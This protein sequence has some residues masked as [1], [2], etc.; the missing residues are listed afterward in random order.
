[1]GEFNR[2][3]DEDS[4]YRDANRTGNNSGKNKIYISS[5]EYINTI[6]Y[7]N[8]LKQQAEDKKN[9]DFKLIITEVKAQ[10]QLD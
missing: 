8:R 1:M 10:E 2:S 7:R 9:N 4:F 3:F 6:Y 5:R